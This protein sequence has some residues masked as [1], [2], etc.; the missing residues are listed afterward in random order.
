MDQFSL[1]DVPT[2]VLNEGLARRSFLV[3]PD[4]LLKCRQRFALN[5]ATTSPASSRST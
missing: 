2:E 3:L 1:T 4:G 5:A